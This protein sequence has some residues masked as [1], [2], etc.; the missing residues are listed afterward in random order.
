MHFKVSKSQT[1]ICLLCPAEK[2]SLSSGLRAKAVSVSDSPSIVD[3]TDESVE[4]TMLM[5][6]PQAQAMKE[7][8]DETMK[9][10][11]P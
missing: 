10:P 4:S 11:P 1:R 8:S 9:G 2:R 5:T 3:F 7:P 6:S